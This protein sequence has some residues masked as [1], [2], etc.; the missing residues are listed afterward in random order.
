MNNHPRKQNY[1]A[2][3]SFAAVRRTPNSY[4]QDSSRNLVWLHVQGGVADQRD[5]GDDAMLDQDIYQE[6]V[7]RVFAQ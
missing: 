3:S 4:W 1:Q 2:V 5:P 7:L 6:A